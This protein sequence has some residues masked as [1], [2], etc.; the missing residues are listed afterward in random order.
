MFALASAYFT[1]ESPSYNVIGID[2]EP[3]A[4]WDNYF[5]AANNAIR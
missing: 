2:W 1:H 4:T 3:L 5:V